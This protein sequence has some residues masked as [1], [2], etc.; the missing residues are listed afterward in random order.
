MKTAFDDYDCPKDIMLHDP[1][2]PSTLRMVFWSSDK[3][4]GLRGRYLGQIMDN[5]NSIKVIRRMGDLGVTV[6][7]I[8]DGV[9]LLRIW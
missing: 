1:S 6:K 4:Q 5:G 3:S 8:S 2:P 7:S 9:R